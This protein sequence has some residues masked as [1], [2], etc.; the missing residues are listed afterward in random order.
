M[1]YKA[2]F[3]DRD[4]TLNIE[5]NYLYRK[6][7]FEFIDGAIE[8]IKIFHDCGYKVIVIT[9]QAGIA[10]GY[11]K[12]EDVIFLHQHISEKLKANNTYVDGYYYC[13]HHKDGTITEY[14]IDCECRKPKAGMLYQAAKD[15]DLDLSKSF[16]IGDNETDIL[17]GKYAH[18]KSCFLVRSGHPIDEKNT[19]ADYVFNSIIDVAIYLNN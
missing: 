7:D 14:T 12:E 4:G 17:S 11:F 18:L 8:S 5:K 19:Q 16:I 10:K 13:P 1:S 6:E 15:H 9:N 2:V 3:L